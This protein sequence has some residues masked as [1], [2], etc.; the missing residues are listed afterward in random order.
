MIYCQQYFII[1]GEFFMRYLKS[2]WLATANFTELNIV[3][4]DTVHPFLSWFSALTMLVM[5]TSVVSV[6]I[7]G[8]TVH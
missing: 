8:V 3:H 7:D 5:H 2:S 6:G 1:V 4:K